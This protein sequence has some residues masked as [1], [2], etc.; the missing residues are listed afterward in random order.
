MITSSCRWKT[1]KVNAAF[2]HKPITHTFN[3]K[4]MNIFVAIQSIY[5]S[6]ID[7]ERMDRSKRQVGPLL[8]TTEGVDLD[9]IAAPTHATLV[10]D[11]SEEDIEVG[12][13]LARR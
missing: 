4:H 3:I 5:G 1:S 8:P 9:A 12:G 10:D 6:L 7:P 13:I 11:L 2:T